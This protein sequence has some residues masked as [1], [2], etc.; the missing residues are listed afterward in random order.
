MPTSTTVKATTRAGVRMLVFP[1]IHRGHRPQT[2]FQPQMNTDSHR[3]N[4]EGSV[5]SR[6]AVYARSARD[7]QL[8]P[9][10]CLVPTLCCLGEDP[11]SPSSAHR[12]HESHSSDINPPRLGTGGSS[13]SPAEGFRGGRTF[14]GT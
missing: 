7:F 5:R 12:F 2:R 8:S 6:S 14:A 4:F 13:T 10:I 1:A 3:W 9:T 11:F